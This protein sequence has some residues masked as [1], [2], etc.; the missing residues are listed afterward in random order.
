[1]LSSGRN[2]AVQY[3]LTAAVV[4][5]PVKISIIDGE[6]GACEAP[7]QHEKLLAVDGL[8]GELLTFRS[9]AVEVVCAPVDDPMPLCM[10]AALIGLSGLNKRINYKRTD[11]EGEGSEE[12]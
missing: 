8:K 9:V 7:P 12:F 5:K 4:S 1:M 2:M 11:F 10:W 3:E 6:Q